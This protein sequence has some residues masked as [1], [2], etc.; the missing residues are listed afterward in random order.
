MADLS[1]IKPTTIE[2]I[3]RLARQ[4]K[5]AEGGVLGHAIERAAK[6][7]GFATYAAARAAL[8]DQKQ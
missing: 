8:K 1:S 6:Q 5:D 2:G 4:I 7:A 3:K